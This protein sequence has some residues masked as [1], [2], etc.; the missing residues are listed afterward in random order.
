[1]DT[2]SKTD[3]EKDNEKHFRAKAAWKNLP[4]NRYAAEA[5]KPLDGFRMK[6]DT[7]VAGFTLFWA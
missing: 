1:M 7:E 5:K 6:F 4:G 3:T 2:K